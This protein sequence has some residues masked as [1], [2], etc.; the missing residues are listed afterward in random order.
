MLHS[1]LFFISS[2]LF[3]LDS[4]GVKPVFFLMDLTET[5]VQLI[6]LE[7][8]QQQPLDMA[9]HQILDGASL[10]SLRSAKVLLKPNLITSRNGLLACTDVRLIAAVGRWFLEQGATAAIGDSP[11]F[12]SAASVL[13]KIGATAVLQALGIPVVEFSE[14]CERVLPSGIKAAMAK[15]AL[16]CDFLVNLPKVKA[17]AQMRVTLAVKNCFGCLSGFHK[18]WWHMQHGGQDSRFPALL[19]ELLTVLPA[20]YTVVD[21]IVAMH[22]SGPIHGNPYPLGLLAGGA[23]P[24][25]VDTALLTVLQIPRETSP[26]W[27][28]A[29]HAGYAGTEREQLVFPLASPEDLLVNDF[30]VPETLNPVRF[31]PFRFVKNF[32]KRLW[33]RRSFG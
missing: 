21:G 26:L 20:S 2:L 31:N 5:T 29:K 25:A 16:D 6:R 1:R 30:L 23:N 24:V 15:A 4:F 7:K 33:L 13:S 11:S 3:R 17:H 32:M 22:V 18:P 8:Y 28:A 10:P 12:G 9:V 14:S 19:N 27:V